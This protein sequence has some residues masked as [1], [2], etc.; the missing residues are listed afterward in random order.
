MNDEDLNDTSATGGDSDLERSEQE[1]TAALRLSLAELRQRVEALEQVLYIMAFDLHESLR[2]ILYSGERL[3]RE[4]DGPPTGHAPEYVAQ[5]IRGANALR[6]LVPQVQDYAEVTRHKEMAEEVDCA[7][8]VAEAQAY[9]KDA[10][11]GSGLTVHIGDLPRLPGVARHVALLFR[12]L[13]DNAIKYRSPDRPGRV[14]VGCRRHEDGWLFWV[15]DNG[16]GIEPTFFRRIF[17][18]G[19]RLHP[20]RHSPGWGFGLAICEKVVIRHGGRIWVTSEP[21]QGSTFY[22]TLSEGCAE[23]TR[24]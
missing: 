7:T 15:R 22:F 5:I 18:L 23:K 24:P 1:R 8:V 12:H 3:R 21:G 14:E 16:I 11:D 2:T 6:L 19:E 13:L 9:L 4:L 17:E 20:R 10:L